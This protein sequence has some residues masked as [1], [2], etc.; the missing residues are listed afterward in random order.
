VVGF[1]M[2]KRR[3]TGSLPLKRNDDS[4]MGLEERKTNAR[5]SAM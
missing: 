3:S 5:A 4:V 2:L 1:Q